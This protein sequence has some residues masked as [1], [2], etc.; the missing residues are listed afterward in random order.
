MLTWQ[1]SIRQAEI[2]PPFL[3]LFKV[4]H[5]LAGGLDPEKSPSKIFI[6]DV[7]EKDWPQ[8]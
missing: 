4:S 1:K 2:Y 6:A 8:K 7:I 5:L 3:G